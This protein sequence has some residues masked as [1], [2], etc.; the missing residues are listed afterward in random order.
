MMNV[1]RIKEKK[2]CVEDLMVYRWINYISFNN[3]LKPSDNDSFLLHLATQ[4]R[5]RS[6]VQRYSLRHQPEIYWLFK[7]KYL[8]KS[9]FLY[10]KNING[11]LVD[12]KFFA[13]SILHFFLTVNKSS[14]KKCFKILKI[15][16][17]HQLIFV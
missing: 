4:V 10:C 13:R 17:N 15:I 1:K 5:P 11:N 12:A 9:T 3:D 2:T 14:K 7:R 16:T 8:L 6:H